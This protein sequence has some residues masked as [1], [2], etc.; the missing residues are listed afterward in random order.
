MELELG[1]K[2][3][4]T[5]EDVSSSVDFRFSK[6]PFGPLVLSRETDSRFI[7]IIHLKGQKTNAVFLN[8][9][10]LFGFLFFMCVRSKTFSFVE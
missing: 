4:R 3:T 9:Y 7:I 10:C 1:L 6:D 8:Y 2:I 5:R